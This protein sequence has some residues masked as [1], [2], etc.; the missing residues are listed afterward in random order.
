MDDQHTLSDFFNFDLDDD[1]LCLTDLLASNKFD[2][3]GDSWISGHN[4]NIIEHLNGFTEKEFQI[5]NK[6]KS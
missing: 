5:L 1:S 6:E 3:E 2:T 4:P